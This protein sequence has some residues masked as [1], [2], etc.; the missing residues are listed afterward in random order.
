MGYGERDKPG[1]DELNQ[2][3]SRG[4]ELPPL[5]FLPERE[6]LKGK[7]DNVEYEYVY[8]K[9]KM[10]YVTNQKSGEQVLDENEQPIPRRQFNITILCQDYTLPNG[11]PRKAWIKLGASLNPKANLPKFLA[12]MGLDYADGDEPTPQAIIDHLKDL[13][14]KFQM[15]NKQGENGEYQ[16]VVWDA[17]KLNL[18][19]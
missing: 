13:N 15:A 16:Q 8:F 3:M 9:G 2:P 10:Q 18:G 17:V 12:N 14:V 11:Q 19:A 1:R 6:W 7:I 5:E 4:K